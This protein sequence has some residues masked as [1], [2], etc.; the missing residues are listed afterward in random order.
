MKYTRKCFTAMLGHLSFWSA[1]T[2]SCSIFNIHSYLS[3]L[4]PLAWIPSF[5]CYGN[6]NCNLVLF[7]LQKS[8]TGGDNQL[9]KRL[10]F[11]P[12]VKPFVIIANN[13]FSGFIKQWDIYSAS[14][15]IVTGLPLL[16][17]PIIRISEFT[18][19]ILYPTPLSDARSVPSTEEVRIQCYFYTVAPITQP[20]LQTSE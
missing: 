14:I 4:I 8:Y 9:N 18:F 13:L 6:H 20:T 12:F 5:P 17:L 19:P 2:D 7:G 11:I 10:L 1:E 15:W 16:I 3:D